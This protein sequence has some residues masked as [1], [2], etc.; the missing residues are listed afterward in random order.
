MKSDTPLPKPNHCSASATRLTSLSRKTGRPRRFSSNSRK[1]RFLWVREGDQCT[2]PRGTS[3][4]PASPNPTPER[5]LSAIP[6]LF[7]ASSKTVNKKSSASWLFSFVLGSSSMNSPTMLPPK[8]RMATV[9]FLS[10]SFTP[11]TMRAAP[12]IL[13]STRGRPRFRSPLLSSRAT[14]SI[15]PA[16]SNSADIPVTLACEIPVRSAI[17]M[18]ATRPI[19]R[20]LES[21]IPRDDFRT[22]SN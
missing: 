11:A 15:S 21:T 19:S 13:R 9:A 14:S 2:K 4:T 3:M 20:M 10:P 12:R 16:S 17:S 22:S 18:R 6:V 7:V 5:S 8:S 1:G